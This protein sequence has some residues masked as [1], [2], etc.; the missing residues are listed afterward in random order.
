MGSNICDQGQL[1]LPEIMT[2]IAIDRGLCSLSGQP[3]L[4]Q[5]MPQVQLLLS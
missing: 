1:V 2:P 4:L 5:L 3:F